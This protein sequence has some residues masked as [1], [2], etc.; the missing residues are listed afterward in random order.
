[1][2]AVEQVLA[3]SAKQKSTSSATPQRHI[4]AQ[5]TG[6]EDFIAAMPRAKLNRAEDFANGREVVAATSAD[7]LR[8]VDISTVEPEIAAFSVIYPEMD[9]WIF[10][11]TIANAIVIN[12][13]RVML[14]YKTQDSAQA[15]GLVNYYAATQP[16]ALI[17]MHKVSGKVTNYESV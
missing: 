4:V 15:V 14:P 6:I 5:N 9:T 2:N 13:K 17:R 1:M 16:G 3:A 10:T 11:S 12:G 7:V 8:R